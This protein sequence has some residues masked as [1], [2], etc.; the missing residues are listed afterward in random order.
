MHVLTHCRSIT[1]V[2][3]VLYGRTKLFTKA[4][5]VIPLYDSLHFYCSR[6]HC[7]L[8]GYVIMPDH[9]HLLLWPQDEH[10]VHPFMRD[11][12]EFTAKRLVRQAE[13]ED[14][15]ALLADSRA[16]GSDTGRGEH[17]VWQDH[18]WDVQVFSERFVRQKLN[19][20][21]RNPLR[22]GLVELPEQYPYS[23]YRNY[24]LGEEWLIE[25]DRSWM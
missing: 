20:I 9:V 14:D 15:T 7:S 2:T 13:V 12:K 18:F 11:F 23:S 16:A 24:V 4:S 5:Y 1:Y 6:Y 19:Y 21:H 8:V 17:K 25:V 10:G 22:A 3:S